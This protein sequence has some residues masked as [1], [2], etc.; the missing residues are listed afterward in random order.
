MS[1]QSE[2]RAIRIDIKWPTNTYVNAEP[3]NAFVFNDIGENVCFALGFVPPPPGI[4]NAQVSEL[5]IEAERTRAA[6]L[7]HLQ[8]VPVAVIAAWIGPQGRQ[9]HHAA[10]RS[11]AVCCLA[12]RRSEFGASCDIV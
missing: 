5:V 10:V 6:T 8:G 1:G 2:Q 7:M 11:L 9:P 4:E 12:G 3:A